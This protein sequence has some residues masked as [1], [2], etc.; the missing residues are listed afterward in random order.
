MILSVRCSVTTWFSMS[1]RSAALGC[2]ILVGIAAW[3]SHLA[4]AEPAAAEPTAEGLEFFEKRI[5]PLLVENCYECHSAAKKTKGGLAL[6][7]RDATLKGGDSGAVIAPGDPE[8]SRLIEAVRYKNRDLQMPPKGALS[9]AQVRDL[10]AWVKM[11]APDPRGAKQVASSGKRTIDIEEGRKFWSF[12]P[13][14]N[15][16]PP[17]VT[18]GGWVKSPVDAFLLAALEQAGLSPAPQADRRTLIRRATFDL[19]GL[20]PTLD[21]IDSFLADPSPEAFERVI[22]RLLAS[23]HYG[24]RWGRHW[25]DVARYADSNGL[26]EN[27]AF[28]H[29]WRY[30]DYVVR[31]F[32]EDKPYDQFLIEQ[33]AGDLLPAASEAQRVENLTATGFLALGARVLAEPDVR[34]MEMDII[35]EQLDALGKAFLGMTL[36]CCRCHDHK[37]DPVPTADYYALA[38]I[39][40]STRSLS[41]EKM[42]NVKF[43]Y[44]HSLATPE[45]VAAKKKHEA[46]VTS[47]REKLTKFIGELRAKLKDE[48]QARAADYLAAGALLPEDADFAQIEKLAA[49]TGL[50]ARYLLT[51]RQYLAQN[52]EHPVFAKWRE[53]AAAGQTEGVRTHYAKLFADAAAAL[54]AAKAKDEKAAKPAEEQLAAAY[55]ALNDKAGFLTIPDKDADAFD[56]GMLAEADKMKGELKALEDKT[57]EPPALMG[58]KDSTITP[59]LPIHIRGSYLSLGKEIE[60]GFPEVIR[61]SQTQPVLPAKQSGRLQLARWMASGE[62][63]LTARVMVNRLWRWHFGAGIVSTTENFGLL[64]DKPSHP[65]LLDWLARRF[66]EEGWSVKSMHR[67]LMRSNAYQMASVNPAVS[68]TSPDPAL[69][70]PDNRLLWRANILRLEAEQIRDAMLAAS[71]SLNTLIGGKTVPLRNRQYV[72]D[73]TSIDATRYETSRR[74]LYLPIIRNHLYDMLEQFDYPDPT[75]PTGNRNSTVVAP[76]TLIMLNAPVVMDAAEKLALKLLAGNANDEARVQQAFVALYARPPSEE[77][78]AR[79]LTFVK[80]QP[81]R[82]QAW[83]LLCHTL[84]A[85]NEFLYLR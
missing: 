70:D 38:A 53:F 29:A 66:I 74:A 81:D 65:A 40:R 14:A 18:N 24:E 4:A 42:G 82:Q 52:T 62:H 48:L 26:D 28:G 11:G 56:T 34:K 50:R 35:D 13:L 36:G 41:E 37:F 76:Q 69:I 73:H 20:P 3:Q 63:P 64:G 45:Q 19:T 77:E 12:Q 25:L 83:T 85:A 15:P 23:P 49:Q 30:R 27:V 22:E 7:A 33:L 60:R 17:V 68:Q 47:R 32:N 75:V 2:L 67:L 46:E 58:V 16:S 39:F 59:V 44:E 5:R 51:C 43:W 21:E 84:I 6:D 78:T 10:E 55:D 57:P 1:A 8:K 71:G 79:A 61:T 31:A 72:F 80:N 9:D 54:Q